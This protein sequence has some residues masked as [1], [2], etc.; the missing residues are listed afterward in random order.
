[1]K[2]WFLALIA[3]MILGLLGAQVQAAEVVRMRFGHVAPPMHAQHKASD[4]F[5]QYVEKE[6]GGRIKCSTH[7]KGQL[8]SHIAML[9]QLQVGTLEMVSVA[10][11]ALTE[12]VPQMALTSLPFMFD[13][14]EEM[15]ALLASPIGAKISAAFPD[16]GLVYG[17]TA[18]HGFKAFLNRKGPVT[19]LEDLKKYKWRVIPNELFLDNYGA[20]GVKPVTLP[21]PEVFSA[22]QRGVI[23]GIDLTPNE[24]WGAKVY[25]VIKYMSLCKLGVNPQVYVASKKWLDNLPEDLKKVVLKSMAAAA[26]WHTETIR[27]EDASLVMPDLEKKGVTIN[28]VSPE[29]L[30]RFREAVKPVHK[31]WRD[32]IGAELYDQAQ[33]FLA[34]KRK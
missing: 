29:E 2:R 25:E 30:A 9:E 18:D 1:M 34:R 28:Q 16:K 31:K 12:F 32:K 20:M 17:G 10:G 22:L 14:E 23:D 27:Q 3:I 26:K 21:W 11:P 24:T 6:S 4:W 8:G 19:K 33:D 13:T 7:P 5:A 15:Y